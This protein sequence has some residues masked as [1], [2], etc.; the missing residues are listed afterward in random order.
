VGRLLQLVVVQAGGGHHLA[1]QSALEQILGAELAAG[2]QLGELRAQP[3]LHVQESVLPG[4]GARRHVRAN[5]AHIRRG[6]RVGGR[7]DGGQ[8]GKGGGRRGGTAAAAATGTAAIPA[9]CLNGGE[10]ATEGQS[11]TGG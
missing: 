6:Q 11:G 1:T 3:E 7:G 4:I 9:A 2:H 10:A 5:A 8:G